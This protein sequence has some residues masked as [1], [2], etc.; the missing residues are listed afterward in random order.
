M[1]LN[2]FA[3]K[4]ITARTCQGLATVSTA[5]AIATCGGDLTNSDAVAHVA[6]PSRSDFSPV[7]DAME[8]HCG[9]LDCHGQVGRNMRL[10]GQY[11]L[12]LSPNDDPL[13][14]ATSEAEYDASYES[15]VGLEP[16]AVSSVVLHNAGPDALTM[17]R[18]ARGIEQHK[19]GQLM[20]EG[21][22]LDRCI[23][24]WLTGSLDAT[25]CAPKARP[26][27]PRAGADG[28]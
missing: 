20:T 16:E 24:G 10:Y 12:R 7:A 4:W 15:I 3:S 17:V 8:L 5:W 22:P 21:D 14:E 25:A 13:T 6:V 2:R 28:G 18:K 27:P 26:E 23:V 19:G 1:Q 11:G 9:T